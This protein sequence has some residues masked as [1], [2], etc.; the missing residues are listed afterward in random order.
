MMLLGVYE[1]GQRGGKINERWLAS[2]GAWKTMWIF[3]RKLTEIGFIKIENH[4]LLF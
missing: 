3:C 4:T 1:G 2:T